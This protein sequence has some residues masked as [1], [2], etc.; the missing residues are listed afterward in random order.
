VR[1][2]VGFLLVA[3]VGASILPAVARSESIRERPLARLNAGVPA[4]PTR[5]LDLVLTL[6]RP[7]SP[8]LLSRLASLG[9]WAWAA[10]HI[11]VAAVRI[12]V[13][14]IDDLRRVEGVVAV[15]PNRSLTVFD[16][17]STGSPPPA[18]PGLAPEAGFGAAVPVP[19][20]GVTGRGVTVAIMD[21]GIDFTHPDLAPAMVANVKFDATGLSAPAPPVEGLPNTDT[22]SGHGTHVAGDAAGRG[23]ASGGAYQGAGRGASSGVR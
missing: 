19:G 7:A 4:Q 12:P 8:N 14:R 13:A 2:I 16:R 18:V 1:R 9:S 5:A 17:L 11:A 6:D 10:R 3:L 15:H 22:T 20:L 21:T 23:I